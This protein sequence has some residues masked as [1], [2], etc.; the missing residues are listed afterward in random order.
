[1]P[2]LKRLSAPSFWKVAKK[3]SKWVVTP[4]AGPHPKAN[5]IP[6]SIALTSILKVAETTSEAKKIIRRGEVF[7]DGVRRK[8]YSHPLGLFDVFSLPAMKKNY[9]IVP[10]RKGLEVVEIGDGDAK[11]K[12]CKIIGKTI[13]RKGK[14]QL[15]LHDGRN[16]LVE[17]GNYSMGDSLL[18][19]LPKVKIVKHVPLKSGNIGV[20]LKGAAAGK[21]ATV[22]DISKGGRKEGLKIV[23]SIGE[24]I[25]T[26]TKDNIFIVGEN[27]P[28]VKMS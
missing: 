21:I 6:M 1:M 9:R 23:C 22:N 20:V 24:Q 15:N 10:G 28:L 16:V 7:V 3:A 12:L 27:S 25:K 14:T 19:E 4:R 11:M 5:S 8:E 26:L 17:N 18:V 13:N 2:H